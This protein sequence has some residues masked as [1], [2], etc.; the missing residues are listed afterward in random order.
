[1]ATTPFVYI[2][3]YVVKKEYL[4]EF[5]NVYGSTGDWVQLFQKADG[6]ILTEL[7]QDASNP[8]RFVTVDFWNSISD[9]DNF[10]NQFAKEFTAIDKHCENFT[11]EERFIGDFNCDTNRF[12]M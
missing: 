8:L 3:E 9:R 12:V 1:M 4:E 7:H 11:E 6:Y 2:W 5:K 10:R